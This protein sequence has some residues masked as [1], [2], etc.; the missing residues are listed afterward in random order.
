MT[1]M[2]TEAAPAKINL[3]LEILGRRGD[4][5]HELSSL[6]AFASCGDTLS[7]TPGRSFS[8]TIDGP[9]AGDVDGENLV[10]RAVAQAR[11]RDP[12]LVTGAFHLE[13]RLP[14]A[15]GL[16]GGSSDAAAAIRLLRGLNQDREAAIDWF[17]LAGSLGADVPVCL[18][19]RAAHMAGIGDRVTPL[20]AF[21]ALW[22]V[23]VNPRLALSTGDVFRALG[24]APVPPE[25]PSIAV[26]RL[27]HVEALLDRLAASRNDLEAPAVR[28]CPAVSDVLIAL[29]TLPNVA[30]TR[31]SGSGATCFGLFRTHAEAV[32]GARQIGA[33]YPQWWV[34]EASL[35]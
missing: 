11:H 14:V 2:T 8:L 31:M 5:Y 21:P 24:S 1:A 6:V 18:T 32:A 15:A 30:L 4:G 34:A 19:A 10:A 7:V 16:G 28:L 17:D 23:L 26:A 3:S 25:S 29:R 22:A 9:F 20:P 27:D 33:R 35:T 12:R 13:K